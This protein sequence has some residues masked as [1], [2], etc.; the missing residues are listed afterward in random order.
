MAIFYYRFQECGT[1]QPCV[2]LSTKRNCAASIFRADGKGDQFSCVSS[3]PTF[4]T[5][6]VQIYSSKFSILIQVE[7][8]DLFSSKWWLTKNEA[9]DVDWMMTE[10]PP[11]TELIWHMI[12][13]SGATN[14]LKN[15]S[16]YFLRIV[17]VLRSWRKWTC[18]PIWSLRIYKESEIT[19]WYMWW[20]LH[21]CVRFIDWAPY[22][23]GFHIHG[24]SPYLHNIC[25]VACSSRNATSE[26]HSNC[27]SYF[28]F[29]IS[30]LSAMWFGSKL[31]T[32][33]I[34]VPW[35]FF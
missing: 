8:I 16:W 2:W 31:V 6:T 25:E 34:L 33:L 15:L 26:T 14:L 29:K 12:S 28:H 10:P 13:P 5:F 1:W 22:P 7:I 20:R 11:N 32:N 3:C 18:V 9:V 19:R 30:S 23:Y 21:L 24:L 27:F 35:R 17:F 4:S